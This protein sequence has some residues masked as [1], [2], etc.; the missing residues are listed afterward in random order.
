MQLNIKNCD[1][2]AYEDVPQ[3]KKS[4]FPTRFLFELH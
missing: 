4:K 2:G 3:W 1:E